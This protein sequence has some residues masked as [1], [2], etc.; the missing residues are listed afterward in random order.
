MKINKLWILFISSSFQL[1]AHEKGKHLPN[2]IQAWDYGKWIKWIGNYHPIALHFPIALIIM[3][4]IAELIGIKSRSPI[5]KQAARFMI[6]AAAITALPTALLGL[7]YGYDVSYDETLSLLFWWHR[8]LGLSTAALAIITACFKE[9]H[10]RKK[11]GV[12]A[13][14]ISL[15]LLVILVII[16]GYLGGE[17][18]FG[19]FHLFP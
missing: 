8:F 13:Y 4:A 2:Q 19:L 1:Q 3:T 14:A 10:I 12:V 7:A 16:T 17:M 18:T 6:I 9:L 11:I 15:A 5:F